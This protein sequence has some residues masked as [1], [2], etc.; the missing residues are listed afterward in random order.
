[1]FPDFHIRLHRARCSTLFPYSTLFRSGFT[2]AFNLPSN[3][4]P[5]PATFQFPFT[6][7]CLTPSRKLLLVHKLPWARVTLRMQG[8][9]I[10]RIID[11]KSTRLNSIH[12]G[13]AH[14]VFRL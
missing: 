14:P 6:A 1:Q 4:L 3:P 9:A 8:A 2:A 13:N 7:H 12:L 11:R 5:A 10:S